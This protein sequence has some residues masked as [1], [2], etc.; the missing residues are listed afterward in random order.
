MND[1]PPFSNDSGRWHDVDVTMRDGVK[2]KTHV[3]MPEGASHAPI[4]LMRMPYEVDIVFTVPCELYARY[5]I[6]CVVQDV[7]GQRQSEGT[8]SPVVHEREDGEDTLAWLDVQPFA[9]SI[10]LVG[11]SY[12]GGAALAASH[13]LPP[14]VKTMVV[15]VFGTSPRDSVGQGGLMHHEL[16]TAWST[17]MP[18]RERTPNAPEAYHRMIEHRP[19][20]EADQ[21]VLGA[22]IPFYREWLEGTSPDAPLWKSKESLALEQVPEDIHVPV[23]IVAGFDDPFLTSSLALYHHLASR[24]DSLL[25]LI[26]TNHLGFQSGERP[27][28]GVDGLYSFKLPIPW[29]LHHLKGVPLPFEGTGVKVWARG[30]ST[31][32]VAP[33][34]PG[35]T[36]TER[37]VLNPDLVNQEPCPQRLLAGTATTPEEVHYRYNP[38]DPWPSEGGARGIAFIFAGGVKP[39]PVTQSWTCRRDVIRFTTAPLKASRRLV[40][41]MALELSVRSSAPDTSFVAKLVDIDEHGRAVHL[42]DAAATM[43]IPA[44][45]E[46]PYAPTTTRRLRLEFWPTEWVLAPDHRLGLWVSSSNFPMFS[47]HPNTST[48]WYLETSPRLAEQTLEL[49]GPSALLLQLLPEAP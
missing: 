39:G 46:G 38:L 30:A 4:V 41:T 29:L 10:A 27:V 25:A 22:P 17:Y 11:Q 19:Q 3:L 45:E 23:L 31:P 35:P 28:D 36:N 16:I 47:V 33:E 8:W 44:H 43:N 34:W 18:N 37:W 26:P 9:D 15:E 6:G 2:L 21:A 1:L 5:G 42:T 24:T 48:P 12:L 13:H 14:K 20:Y 49:G 40:G 32:R 7:R